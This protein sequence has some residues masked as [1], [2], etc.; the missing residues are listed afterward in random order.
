[1]KVFV[2]IVLVVILGSL[3]FNI[4]SYES[5]YGFSSDV[6]R[7]YIIGVGAGICGLILGLIILQYLRLKSIQDTKAKQDA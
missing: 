2:Y 5:D 6:N 3:I 1:M 7:P 4:V